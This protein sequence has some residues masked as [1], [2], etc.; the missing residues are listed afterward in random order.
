MRIVTVSKATM[1]HHIRRKHIKC[2]RWSFC[3]MVT[4][5]MKWK[6]DKLT[7]QNNLWERVTIFYDRETSDFIFG[8]V[9]FFFLATIYL[10]KYYYSYHFPGNKHSWFIISPILLFFWMSCILLIRFNTYNMPAFPSL[11]FHRHKNRLDLYN[12]VQQLRYFNRFKNNN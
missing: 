1:K 5:T 9:Q 4:S 7:L 6:S 2:T 11:L 8:S 3:K 12:L 10:E